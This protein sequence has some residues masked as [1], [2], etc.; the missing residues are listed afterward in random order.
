MHHRLKDRLIRLETS[1]SLMLSGERPFMGGTNLMVLLVAGH[2]GGMTAHEAVGEAYGRALGYAGGFE[3]RSV[4]SLEHGSPAG[5]GRDRRHAEAVAR[6]LTLKGVSAEE[7]GGPV[8]DALRALYDD[9]PEHV[10]QH[11]FGRE[12]G[13]SL[14]EVMDMFL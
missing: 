11:P 7:G 10:R 14:N 2:L 5:E 8:C 3:L 12:V 1:R 9:L 4:L 13:T 6:L